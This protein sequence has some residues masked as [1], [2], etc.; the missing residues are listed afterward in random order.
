MSPRAEVHAAHGDFDVVHDL[1]RELVEVAVVL[2]GLRATAVARG[3][4]ALAFCLGGV[5]ARG[6]LGVDG[7][8][9]GAAGG[10]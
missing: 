4:G 8:R 5:E 1:L 3:D 6:E 2:L 9:I 7:G 10:V